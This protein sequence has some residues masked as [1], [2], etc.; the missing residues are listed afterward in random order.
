M[1]TRLATTFTSPNSVLFGKRLQK[2]RFPFIFIQALGRWI[3]G[4]FSTDSRYA[5]CI[6]EWRR[7]RVI[8]FSE[9]SIHDRHR[10]LRYC[11]GGDPVMISTGS[12]ELNR[13]D[14]RDVVHNTRQRAKK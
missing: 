8:A 10:T 7:S 9:S 2:P 11:A 4:M 14:A 13:L 5:S 12:N 1:I 6:V 3:D